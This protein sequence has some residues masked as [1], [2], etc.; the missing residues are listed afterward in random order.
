MKL[1]L[2]RYCEAIVVADLKPDEHFSEGKLS[3]AVAYAQKIRA[4]YI[5]V[6]RGPDQRIATYS[7]SGDLVPKVKAK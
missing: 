6:Y 3:K 1:T 4:S 2:D 7:A 5:E